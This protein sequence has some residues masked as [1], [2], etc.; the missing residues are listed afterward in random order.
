MWIMATSLCQAAIAQSGGL[1]P[2]LINLA[3]DAA[4]AA[5]A[6]Q[7]VFD[8]APMDAVKAAVRPPHPKPAPVD[9]DDPRETGPDADFD[10]LPF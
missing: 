2:D 6:A 10:D 8:G 5:R 4:N 1:L 7:R 9:P 3:R